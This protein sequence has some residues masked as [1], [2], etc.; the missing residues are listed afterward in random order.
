MNIEPRPKR[1]YTIRNRTA[2]EKD[3]KFWCKT[4][5]QYL[6]ASAFNKHSTRS[7]G[8]SARCAS[9]N[10]DV[11]YQ[12]KYGITLTRYNEMLEEQGGK[13]ALCNEECSTGRTLA[14]DHCHKTGKVR[15]LLC[16]ECNTALARVEIPGWA[17]KAVA[18]IKEHR[19]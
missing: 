18:Y 17:K 16:A 9:C 10:R 12:I 6:D 7:T 11:K 19:G 1:K 2:I 13:C 14:I 8:L 5:K 4:C 15:G 3:G